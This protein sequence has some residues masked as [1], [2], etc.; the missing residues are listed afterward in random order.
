MIID[1]LPALVADMHE[2]LELRTGKFNNMVALW[3]EQPSKELESSLAHLD[4]E[5]TEMKINYA[6][7]CSLLEERKN[8]ANI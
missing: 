6:E 3:Q 8:A 5:I 2:R 4:S 7:L 1:M